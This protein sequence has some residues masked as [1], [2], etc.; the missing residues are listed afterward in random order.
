MVNQ[1]NA[2]GIYRQASRCV[3]HIFMRARK[4]FGRKPLH[5]HPTAEVAEQQQVHTFDAIF[6]VIILAVL[7]CFMNGYQFTTRL[8][9]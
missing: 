1:C 6:Y 7:L 8:L 5:Q 4:F 9:W 2:F 3:T